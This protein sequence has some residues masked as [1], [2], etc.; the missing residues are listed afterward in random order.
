MNTPSSSVQVYQQNGV[1]YV[2]LVFV[3]TVNI[4][5]CRVFPYS[6]F[7]G[8][9]ATNGQGLAAAIFGF[10]S[11]YD[12]TLVGS[13]CGETQLVPDAASFGALGHNATHALVFGALSS[14]V[15][16]APFALDP[17]GFLRRMTEK[18]KAEFGLA[19]QTGFESEFCLLRDG[20]PLDNAVY[21]QVA[22]FENPTSLRIL[23]S[24][25]D[26]LEAMKIQ[27]EQFH[28]ESASGQFEIVTRYNPVLTAVDNLIKTRI[29]IKE[30]AARES[31]VA[32]F[33]PKLY[34]T[35][36]GT[37]SH[38]HM[39]LWSLTN[40]SQNMS[41]TPTPPRHDSKMSAWDPVSHLMTGHMTPTAAHFM[42]GVLHHLPS[43]MALTTPTPMSFERIQPCFWSGAFQIWGV[44]NREAPVRLS[45]DASHF[46]LKALD[47]TANPYLAMGAILCAGMDGLRKEMQLPSAVQMDPGVL[48]Q[49][50]RD[51]MGIKR[52]PVTLEDA[53]E[54]LKG[55]MV[56]EEGM[57]KEL[58]ENYVVVK[59]KEAAAM[60][61]MEKEIVKQIMIDRY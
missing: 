20:K 48:S 21:A 57:G 37:A 53:L 42:A 19:L 55:N 24:I 51:A 41:S 1:K 6:R 30:I 18:L 28:P 47:G 27:V 56:L 16:K 10:P 23:E 8:E 36:A 9:I 35:Q 14:P 61:G 25:V 32:T 2:R 13:P 46:E 33:A 11:L 39:S 40:P 44:Q 3:D 38:V 26:S 45:H 31:C 7:V 29:T 43:L 5:R 58:F 22:A 54:Y 4:V 49:D 59:T 12:A 34:P 60:K 15:S 52:L 50:E 17:R